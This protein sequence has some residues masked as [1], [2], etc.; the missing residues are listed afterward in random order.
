M[1]DGTYD[2]QET[3]LETC[4]KSQRTLFDLIPSSKTNDPLPSFEAADRVNKSGARQA[5]IERVY[6]AVQRH[7][8]FTSHE[9]SYIV[10]LERH[11]TARRLSDL[12]N[13]GL[14]RQG[15]KRRCAKGGAEAVTWFLENR[16][17]ENT[18]DTE[19]NFN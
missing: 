4:T 1:S 7:Q 5:N 17:T 2:N 11:E 14:A 9:L 8:G 12:K 6:K 10:D 18:E 16:T 15:P 3:P 19:S 13:M